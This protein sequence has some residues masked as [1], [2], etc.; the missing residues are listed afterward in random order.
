MSD[1]Q[2]KSFIERIQNLNEEKQ[3]IQ[4]DIKDVYGEAK[5]TGY[6]TKILRLVIKLL[7]IDKDELE[8]QQALVDT[9]MN[10]LQGTKLVS[11]NND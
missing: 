7:S 2:L 10:S 11:N 6:D 4:N 9:Y 8:E 3:A 1:G 5:G